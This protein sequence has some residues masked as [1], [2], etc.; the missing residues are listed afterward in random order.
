MYSTRF[1]LVFTFLLLAKTGSSIPIN[2]PSITTSGPAYFNTIETGR[3][4]GGPYI[5]AD[6]SATASGSISFTSTGVF[7]SNTY[8]AQLSS[9]YT[10]NADANFG[11][12]VTIG[13][14]ISD[15]NSGTINITIPAGTNGGQYEIRVIS[16]S[17][18]VYGISSGLFIING[19][20][21]HSDID[22][23]FRSKISGDWNDL[24]TWES[25]RSGG[26]WI[27]ATLIPNYLATYID[28]RAGYTVTITSSVDINATGVNGTLKLL[29]GNGNNGHI[30]IQPHSSVI[31]YSM[32]IQPGGVF[33]VVSSSATYAEAI[34]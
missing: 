26:T 13:T 19:G 12:P 32:I 17:P 18:A 1:I 4:E 16:S 3:P 9:R 27:P 23:V 14:L 2:Y 28:I 20:Y 29:N 11:N 6:C 21:C 7:T 33:Q 8:T 24:N 31:Y 15:A 30:T 34:T 25:S 5:L 10:S 22:D